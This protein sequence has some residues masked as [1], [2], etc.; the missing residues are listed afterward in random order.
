MPII[1][2]KLVARPRNVPTE[3]RWMP[4]K[5]AGFVDAPGPKCYLQ[6]VTAHSSSGLGHRPLKAEIRG[7]NPLCATTRP[8]SPCRV[9]WFKKPALLRGFFGSCCP[10]SLVESEEFGQV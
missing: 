9:D 7:S 4:Q 8:G 5:R 6:R 2:R 3:P 1:W 10:V